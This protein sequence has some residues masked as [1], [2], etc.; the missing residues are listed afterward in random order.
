MANVGILKA[1]D[2]VEVEWLVY[3]EVSWKILSL[4]ETS[5]AGFMSLENI[6]AQDSVLYGRI[7]YV[8]IT[9]CISSIVSESVSLQRK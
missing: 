1:S 7:L 9:T 3:C 5:F 4:V 8:F 6:T 2:L